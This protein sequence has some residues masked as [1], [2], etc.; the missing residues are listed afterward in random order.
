[1]L[2]RVSAIND[3]REYQSAA[4]RENSLNFLFGRSMR[5]Y[6]SVVRDSCLLQDFEVFS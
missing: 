5:D 1:M 4:I 2:P 6:Q 3:S